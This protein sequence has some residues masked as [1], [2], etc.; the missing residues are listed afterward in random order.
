MSASASLDGEDIATLVLLQSLLAKGEDAPTEEEALGLILAL[1]MLALGREC[2]GE[3]VAL[4]TPIAEA[5]D[6]IPPYDTSEERS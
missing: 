2:A 4:L 3:V 1:G 6:K 5:I